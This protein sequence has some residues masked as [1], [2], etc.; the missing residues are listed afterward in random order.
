[1]F[2]PASAGFFVFVDMCACQI[3]ALQL[4]RILYNTLSEN[5]C[6][7]KQRAAKRSGIQTLAVKP[8]LD[9]LKPDLDKPYDF[10]AS[11]EVHNLDVA[12]TG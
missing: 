7:R 4:W 12:R 9:P 6:P 1:L 2:N 8:G 11:A 3:N 10:H 5:F